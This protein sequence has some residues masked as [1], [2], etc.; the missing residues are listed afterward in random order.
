[1]NSI[2]LWGA[3]RARVLLLGALL[4]CGLAASLSG[5]C[6]GGTL[7]PGGVVAGKTW[8]I[9]GS[10][11]RVTANLTL[12]AVTIQAGVRVCVSAG[13]SIQVV[14]WLRTEGTADRPVVFQSASGRWSGMGFSG[15]RLSTLRH[16]Q[17][18]GTSGGAVRVTDAPLTMTDCSMTGGTV[19]NGG[20]SGLWLRLNNGTTVVRL[21]RC[22]IR[23]HRMTYAGPRCNRGGT[24]TG[25]GSGIQAVT[26]ATSRLQLVDCNLI[27]NRVNRSGVANTR[28]GGMWLRGNAE[29]TR[30]SIQRNT[31]ASFS[32][33]CNPPGT[34]NSS[35]IGA[36]VFASD[37]NLTVVGC[38]IARN[39]A[40]AVGG[41]NGSGYCDGAA[42]YFAKGG[43]A[44]AKLTMRHTV[45]ARN[46]STTARSGNNADRKSAL[47]L[48]GDADLLHVTLRNPGL[49]GLVVRSGTVT[50]QNSILWGNTRSIV[51][52]PTVTHSDVQGGFAGSGNQNRNPAFAGATD[53]RIV[54]G[55]PCEDAGDPQSSP[56]ASRPPS[57]GRLRADQGAHG[58][59]ARDAW[60][61]GRRKT[62]TF[63]PDTVRAPAPVTLAAAGGSAGMPA[64]IF[65]SSVNGMPIAAGPAS[66]IPI[67]FPFA[68][69]WEFRVPMSLPVMMKAK[70]GFRWIGLDYWRRV[71]SS[72]E[73][74][75]TNR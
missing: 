14:S 49:S 32:T 31:C 71:V 33:G 43:R 3:R 60:F 68:V 28:G 47:S 6:T 2:E 37:G 39:S 51:G 63:A 64:M 65:L 15:A 73:G 36:G 56:N 44:S 30:C 55:S 1:M 34:A 50:V 4:P 29:L 61:S 69:D 18:S 67:I 66:A 7:V 5:Q 75:L 20:G 40:T 26:N 16:T 25:G 12:S 9:A 10:P 22:T 74:F 21:E 13:K 19:G 62:L 58:G 8:T 45:I 53:D 38:V 35:A 70:F 57:I 72:E 24:P 27:D 42:L 52:L 48:N 41:N 54:I 17:I 46:T 23:G 11:Y 59:G